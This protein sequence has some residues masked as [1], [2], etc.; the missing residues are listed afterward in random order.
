MTKDQVVARIPA[1]LKL[2]ESLF[3]SEARVAAIPRFLSDG[4]KVQGM[5][6]NHGA[7][8]IP[9]DAPWRSMYLTDSPHDGM[10]FWLQVNLEEI[11]SCAR[12]AGMPVVG[13]VWLFIQTTGSMW[14]AEVKFDP[15][16]S[17]DITWL[18]QR[19]KSKG[20]AAWHYHVMLPESVAAIDATG[21]AALECT[22]FD[23]AQSLAIMRGEDFY[24]GGYPFPVQS[25]SEDFRE[26]AVCSMPTDWL[27]DCASVHLHYSKVKGWWGT[28]ESH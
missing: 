4:D 2:Y 26:T 25:E 23:F 5:T 3:M 27:H 28:I 6:R 11:P 7:P 21:D 16:P 12:L 18:P 24:F 14:S 13:M 15:R 1:D 8:D 22:Y 10:C 20:Q 17:A 9:E 19:E